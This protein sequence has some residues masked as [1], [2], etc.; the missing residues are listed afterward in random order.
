MYV[1]ELR[2][3]YYNQ[4]YLSWVFCLLYIQ[5]ENNEKCYLQSVTLNS[6]Q[7]SSGGEKKKFVD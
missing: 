1:P 4:K 3:E 2:I 5:A 7:V 6:S